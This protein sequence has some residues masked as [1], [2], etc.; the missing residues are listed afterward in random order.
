MI[1]WQ[2]L[3]GLS[4]IVFSL[5]LVFEKKVL[6]NEDTNPIVF[7]FSFQFI[8]GLMILVLTLVSGQLKFGDFSKIWPNLLVLTALYG[9]GNVFYFRG[10]KQ[11]E[12]SVF[13]II[14]NSSYIFTILGSGFFLNQFL[15]IR[16]IIGVFLI[17]LSIILINWVKGKLK[18]DKGLSLILLGAAC[19]GFEII[20][21]KYMIDGFSVFAFLSIGFILP[22][23]LMASIYHK[24]L[25]DVK[26]ILKPNFF[27]FCIFYM[28]QAL[29]YFFALKSTDNMSQFAGIAMF[30]SIL[31]VLMSV[32][33]LK[34][35]HCLKTKLLASLIGFIGLLL[36]K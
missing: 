29:I 9:F 19:F 16:Q 15:N 27:I 25:K 23:I 36:I 20:N 30:G 2:L 33:L 28:T 1:F 8:T 17:F 5:S 7:A 3:L 6:N 35:T 11:T 14:S 13:T 24:Q 4:L 10:L 34:E 22:S 12:A 21:D 32:L 26:K 18:F 31:N